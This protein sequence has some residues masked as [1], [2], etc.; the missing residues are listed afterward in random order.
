M[1]LDAASTG[2]LNAVALSLII[3]YAGSPPHIR[4]GEDKEA[5]THFGSR[6][7]AVC[8][9]IRSDRIRNLS[10]SASGSSRSRLT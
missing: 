8:T 10:S 7:L 1:T 9:S 5:A 6:L 3:Q 4:R 2:W